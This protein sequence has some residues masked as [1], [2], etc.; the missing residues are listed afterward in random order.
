MSIATAT[1]SSLTHTSYVESV[2]L[3]AREIAPED[4]A[5]RWRQ[6]VE[7][8]RIQTLTTAIKLGQQSSTII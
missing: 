2:H 4:D 7:Q 1:F 6:N 5:H 8:K 3:A